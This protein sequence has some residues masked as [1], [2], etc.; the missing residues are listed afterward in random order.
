MGTFA[1]LPR[2]LYPPLSSV[3]LQN[4]PTATQRIELQLARS[5]LENN[6]RTP[7]LQGLGGIFVAIGLLATW[8]QTKISRE[9][10]ITD[11]FTHA[12]DQL[13]ND[14]PEVRVGGDIES[15]AAELGWAGVLAPAPRS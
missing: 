2:L 5:A 8:Q 13:G 14:R 7:L 12:V 6:A 11:R 15:D 10:Q 9:G 4:V 3:E 1:L